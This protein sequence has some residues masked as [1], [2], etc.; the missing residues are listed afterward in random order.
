MG[1]PNSSSRNPMSLD[2]TT[3]ELT[4][5]ARRTLHVL[6]DAGTLSFHALQRRV[7]EQVWR[8]PRVDPRMLERG[9]AELANNRRPRRGAVPFHGPWS[10]LRRI[11]VTPNITRTNSEQHAYTVATAYAGRLRS[12]AAHL[13]VQSTLELVRRVAEALQV[14]A[15]SP[16]IVETRVV[17]V[18]DDV[19][20]DAHTAVTDLDVPQGSPF[21]L[22]ITNELDW[23]YPD[24]PR[25]WRHLQRCNEDGVRAIFIARKIYFPTFSLLKRLGAFGLQLHFLH[26]ADDTET[27]ARAAVSAVDWPQVASTAAA[28]DHPALGVLQNQYLRKPDRDAV[29]SDAN[30]QIRAGI[31]L[32][33]SS[34]SEPQTEQLLLWS[35][36][37]EAGLPPKWLGTLQ[38]L[39][40]WST[41]I[42]PR[43]RRR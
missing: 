8:G 5:I 42:P 23:L 39:L 40:A 6:R 12:A 22:W 24:D 15:R 1:S 10:P 26:V 28:L 18:G 34:G 25:V 33:L 19:S 7:T 43:G 14:R 30:R 11:F 17:E 9:L 4:E 41:Y 16:E 32:G 37:P 21:R 13:D 29:P 2:L 27:A 38:R 3:A 36:R 35:E 31:E 20:Y